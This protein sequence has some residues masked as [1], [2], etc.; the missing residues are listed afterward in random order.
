MPSVTGVQTC[1]LDRKSTRLNSSHGSIS[2]AVF[3]L[4]KKIAETIRP[5]TD[6]FDVII[7]DEASQYGP[8]ALFLTYLAKQIIVVG[9]D[10]QTSPDS[11]G[12]DRD[13]VELLRKKHIEDLPHSDVL[14]VD[15]SFFDKA[16]VRYGGR[17]RIL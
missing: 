7:I 3:C 8:E 14:G 16:E 1:A 5:G 6:S 11:V 15:N 17:L 10:K 4:I 9:D 12:L 2:Y 13:E